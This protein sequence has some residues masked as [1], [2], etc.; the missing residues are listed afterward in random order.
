MKYILKSV[1]QLEIETEVDDTQEPSASTMEFLVQQDLLE[2]GYT[3]DEIKTL[4][5][6]K[7][8]VN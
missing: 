7:V 4:K 8:P 5:F 1:L 2:L 3:C 6:E